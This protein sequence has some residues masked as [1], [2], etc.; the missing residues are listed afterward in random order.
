MKAKE[1]SMNQIGGVRTYSFT[2]VPFSRGLAVNKARMVREK[3][4]RP[5]DTDESP[6]RTGQ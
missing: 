4:R 5:S 3:N 6:C 2:C 1:M